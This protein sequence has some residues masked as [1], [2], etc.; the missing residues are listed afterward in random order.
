MDNVY[1]ARGP[2]CCRQGGDPTLEFRPQQFLVIAQYTHSTADDLEK[3]GLKQVVTPGAGRTFSVPIGIE[4][5]FFRL[6]GAT[7][8]LVAH[9]GNRLILR[10]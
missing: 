5:R 10:Y 8:T 1:R 4:N 2:G 9:E 6:R 7:I 3:R